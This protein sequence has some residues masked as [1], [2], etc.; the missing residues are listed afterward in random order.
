MAGSRRQFLAVL[1]VGIVVS[2]GISGLL[3]NRPQSLRTEPMSD[4]PGFRRMVQGP[5][6]GGVPD[7]FV[8]LDSRGAPPPQGD[9]AD[10]FTTPR[11]T[12]QIPVAVFSDFNCPYCRVLTRMVADEAEAGAIAVTWHELPLLGPGSEVA[13][14]A[15]IA[16]DMQ[17]GYLAFHKRLMRSA[18]RPSEAYL[19]DLAVEQGLDPQRLLADMYGPEAEDRLR[20]SVALAHRFGIIG[21]PAM[22]VG[23]VLVL[24]EISQRNFRRLIAEQAGGTGAA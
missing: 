20:R 7:P 1:T 14:R 22:V 9:L 5:V 21:T 18:F 4:P 23:K 17:G 3:R 24:G 12:A 2:A 6:S 15:A 16:A 13:A 8:G 10:L 19:A 11:T